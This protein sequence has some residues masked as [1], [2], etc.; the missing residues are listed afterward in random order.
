LL[1]E[2]NLELIPAPSYEELLASLAMQFFHKF[3]NGSGLITVLAL[4]L[5]AGFLAPHPIHE[6]ILKRVLG[7][8]LAESLEN[9]M[10][11]HIVHMLQKIKP[12]PALMADLQVIFRARVLL[13]KANVSHLSHCLQNM[14]SLCRDW[15]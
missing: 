12:M 7:G 10:R 1:K 2:A 14:I 15:R 13:F 9:H 3:V 8:S 4:K 5:R 11:A 6:L